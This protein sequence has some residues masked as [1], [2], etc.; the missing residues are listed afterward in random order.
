M[1]YSLHE[2]PQSLS[3]SMA[4][5]FTF[6]DNPQFKHILE[7]AQQR[8]LQSLSIDFDKVSFI[9]SAGLGMLL[10]L[11]DVC[12][13]KKISITLTRAHGQVAKVFDISKFNE[14]FTIT[15]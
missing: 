15:A 9:D 14:L 4:G 8:N 5:Q 7:Y 1:E 12:Q 13:E 6:G 10:L 11:R 3:V 2:Q